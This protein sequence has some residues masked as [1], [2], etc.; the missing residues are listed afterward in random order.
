M[1]TLAIKRYLGYNKH[2]E[3][4]LV[5]WFACFIAVIVT[6]SG[7]ATK[8]KSKHVEPGS[9]VRAIPPSKP[10]VYIEANIPAMEMTVYENGRPKFTKP[11]AIGRGIYPTP[12]LESSIK[13]IE[14]NPWWYP[15]P[16]DWAKDDKPTPP[17]PSNPLG[18]VKMALSDGILF[19]G[20]NKEKTIGTPASHGCMRMRND[21]AVEV[22][23]YLQN[24]F[25]N[26]N[27]PHLL[28]I[29]KK[30]RK[31]TYTVQLD[32][33][34]PVGLIYKPVIL[35]DKMLIFYPDHY[36]KLMRREA[37][38]IGE[39]LA[40]GATQKC[41]DIDK[42]KELVKKWPPRGTKI[43]IKSLLREEPDCGNK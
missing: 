38:V 35:R 9:A 22:A 34:I 25:S 14:W 2:M 13:K 21:D 17:G 19:H 37:A 29:Y 11:I 4:R 12:A 1:L 8:E 15:P 43:E 33:E 42:L 10:D 24:T 20:T 32:T 41:I 3:N 16:S 6:F 26:K 5:T 23:W 18:L 36:H 30:N 7:C 31:T 27:D 39:I 40:S 28:E